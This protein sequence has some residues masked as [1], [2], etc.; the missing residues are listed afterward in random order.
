MTATDKTA[1]AGKSSSRRNG[2]ATKTTKRKA[3]AARKAASPSQIPPVAAPD[4][5]A[6]AP[7]AVDHDPHWRM[8]AVTA[9]HKAEQ[10]GFEPGHE[11]TDWLEA[12]NEVVATLPGG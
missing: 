12:E 4:K 6:S 3:P 7:I 2:T 9:Y 1:P 10:R 11:L 8:I 5:T